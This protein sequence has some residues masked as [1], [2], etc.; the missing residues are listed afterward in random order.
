MAYSFHPFPVIRASKNALTTALLI[1]LII[2]FRET[3]GSMA[4]PLALVVLAFGTVSILS[5]FAIAST[6]SITLEEKTIIY[7]FGV[8]TRTEYNLP[9]SKIT[10]ARFSQGVVEQLLGLGTLTLDTAGYTDIPLHIHDIRLPDIRKTL[11]AING[12]EPKKT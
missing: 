2:M 10:E 11:D 3:L 9:Y 8:F 1:L 5:A 12:S 4:L 7:R 6:F